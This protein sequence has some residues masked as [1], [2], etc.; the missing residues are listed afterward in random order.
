MIIKEMNG[1]NIMIMINGHIGG[2]QMRNNK[3]IFFFIIAISFILAACSGTEDP[4]EEIESNMSSNVTDFEYTTQDEETL[5]ADD[6]EGE[7]WI[8]DFIFTNCTT[9]CLPMTSNMAEL[10]RMLDEEDVDA[11][12]VSFSVDPDYD[13]PDVLKEYAEQYDAD[14]TNWTFLTGYDFDTIKEFSI[15]SFKSLVQE[16]E[17]GDDQVTH[18]TRFFLVNPE[19]EIIKNYD[20]VEVEE[21][22][23]IVDDLKTLQQ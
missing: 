9:V 11:E 21:M 20:G 13:S 22:N 6:L 23:D 16:P 8:A 14:L 17:K 5:S 12:L 18:G 10:Q 15:K 3:F 4:E 2:Y 1:S 19:G 7:W